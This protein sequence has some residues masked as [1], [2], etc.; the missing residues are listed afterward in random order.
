MKKCTFILECGNHPLIHDLVLDLNRLLSMRW[1]SYVP[2]EQVGEY[3]CLPAYVDGI[4]V[5]TRIGETILCYFCYMSYFFFRRQQQIMYLV[6]HLNQKYFPIIIFMIR[7]I[8]C[9]M[10]DFYHHMQSCIKVT[11]SLRSVL[12]TKSKS[13][14][15]QQGFL[16]ANCQII[17][18]LRIYYFVHELSLVCM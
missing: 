14:V 4:R 7:K 6:C 9:F 15:S 13:T 3:E 1:N 17:S 11:T 2:I 12:M 8:L 18:F 5:R 16:F 10:P